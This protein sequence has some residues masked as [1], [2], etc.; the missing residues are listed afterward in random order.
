M[1]FSGITIGMYQ[2]GVRRQ[3]LITHNSRTL[4]TAWVAPRGNPTYA[5]RLFQAWYRHPAS[6]MNTPFS[7]SGMASVSPVTSREASLPF[8]WWTGFRTSS[9]FRLGG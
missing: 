9:W 8:L 5:L 1:I 6:F 4:A 3:L 2:A 7:P